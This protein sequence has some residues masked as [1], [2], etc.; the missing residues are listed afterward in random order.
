MRLLVPLLVLTVGCSP[1]ARL[2]IRSQ[3]D[4]RT[5]ATAASDYWLAVRWGDVG[6]A[7]AFLESPE[8]RLRLGRLASEP[9]VRVTDAQVVQV[10]IGDELPE[11][12]EPETRE[13]VAVVRVE[14]YDVVSGRVDIVTLEQHWVLVGHDWRVDAERSPLGADRPW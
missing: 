13:G 6:T 8:E 14:G 9:K 10:V 3:R 2:K 5:L 7:A 12:R 1:A 11:A 4:T